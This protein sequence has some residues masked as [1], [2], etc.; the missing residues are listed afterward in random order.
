[1]PAAAELWQRRFLAMK[2]ISRVIAAGADAECS[3]A[4]PYIEP[5]EEAAGPATVAGGDTPR[6][7]EKTHS[8]PWVR[9]S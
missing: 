2:K 6:E 9:S 4:T 5:R 8:K 7:G 1:M 3:A